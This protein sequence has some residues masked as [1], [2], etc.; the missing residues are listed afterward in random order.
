MRDKENQ[1]FLDTRFG[2][3][4]SVYSMVKGNLL[5]RSFLQDNDAA[6]VF[7]QWLQKGAL[8]PCCMFFVIISSNQRETQRKRGPLY[9]SCFAG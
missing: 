6:F 1:S 2:F 9:E 3:S 8:L 4:S 7:S 5:C